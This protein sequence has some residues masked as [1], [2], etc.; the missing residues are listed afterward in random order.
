MV[1]ITKEITYWE[2]E[3]DNLTVNTLKLVNTI[4]DE[5][6]NTHYNYVYEIAQI[7]GNDLD[8]IE[9]KIVNSAM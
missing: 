7:D 4:V 8:V 2:S 5:R 9:L 3:Y 6:L 1:Q